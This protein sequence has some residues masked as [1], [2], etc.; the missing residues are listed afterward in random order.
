MTAKASAGAG[1]NDGAG[2]VLP[3]HWLGCV[4]YGGGG[5]KAPVATG[6][7]TGGCHK[8]STS[9]PV[10]RSRTFLPKFYCFS[11]LYIVSY[12]YHILEE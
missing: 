11:P 4:R 7:R 8:V 5:A 12:T 3:K 9:V 10:Q 2:I 6:M 1:Q